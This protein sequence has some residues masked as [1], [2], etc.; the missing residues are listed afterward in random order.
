MDPLKKSFALKTSS[1]EEMNDISLKLGW[2]IRY[3]Q[4]GPGVFHGEY[5]EGTSKTFTVTKESLSV[6]VSIHGGTIPGYIAVGM[7]HSPEPAK[8]NGLDLRAPHFFVIKS[9]AEFDFVT[10]GPGNILLSLFPE[11]RLE[12]IF[13][14]FDTIKTANEKVRVF[15]G[16]TNGEAECFKSWFQNWPYDPFWQT[17]IGSKAL[18]HQLEEIVYSFLGGIAENL[19]RKVGAKGPRLNRSKKRINRL[20]D[21]LHCHPD[22]LVSIEG[23]CQTSGLS[24][25]NLFYNFKEYTGYTPGNYFKHIRL[26]ALHRELLDGILSVTSLAHKYNFYNLGEFSAIYKNIFI[27]LPSQT[28]KKICS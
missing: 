10:K 22:Q 21:Y 24:R 20:I 28:R 19:E 3:S 7:Y 17:E 27:E 18:T 8:I 1:M 15:F 2:D 23:M 4:L 13:G 9:G 6:P 12:E 26:S 11:C 25:R 5:Q 14:S 16:G